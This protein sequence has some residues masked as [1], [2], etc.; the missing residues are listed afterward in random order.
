MI[1]FLRSFQQGVTVRMSDFA[2]YVQSI[3][4]EA[5]FDSLDGRWTTLFLV[6]C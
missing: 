4:V 3:F 5:S 1:G 2:A 6:V